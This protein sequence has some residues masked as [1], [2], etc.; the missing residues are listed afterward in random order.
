MNATEFSKKV[1]ANIANDNATPQQLYHAVQEFF[2]C[3]SHSVL[4][5]E[6]VEIRY[7]GSFT[8]KE[9]K[10]YTARNPRTGQKVKLPVHKKVNF[11]ESR[12]IATKL[13]EI[14]ET[15]N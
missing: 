7:F 2:S 13:V 11:R 12:Q 9:N 1:K 4:R 14:S 5:G 10:A 8:T 6:R 15:G 3:I